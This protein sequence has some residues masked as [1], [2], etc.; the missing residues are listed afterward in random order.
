MTNIVEIIETIENCIADDE[1]GAGYLMD[2]FKSEPGQAALEILKDFKLLVDL[3]K[4]A[5]GGKWACVTHAN[6]NLGPEIHF[7]P[8]KGGVRLHKN[9]PNAEAIVEY[10]S[11]S[12][13]ILSKYTEEL[14]KPEVR[15][16]QCGCVVDDILDHIDE[17]C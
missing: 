3:R 2:M 11:F 15:C 9:T 6:H 13:N 17:S 16:P 12:A 10:V 5:T 14:H 7:S 4:K 8:H 1:D